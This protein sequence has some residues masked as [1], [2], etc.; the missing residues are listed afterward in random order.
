MQSPET[1]QKWPDERHEKAVKDVEE[2]RH[3]LD[4][5]RSEIENHPK[6]EAAI[7]K[8]ELALENLTIRSGGM[9]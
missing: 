1:E 9:L 3:L 7:V 6:L 2:A 5:L 8:L 4:A